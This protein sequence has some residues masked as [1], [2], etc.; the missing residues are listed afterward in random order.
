MFATTLR[1]PATAWATRPAPSTWRGS[2][3]V[4]VRVTT[5]EGLTATASLNPLA[6]GAYSTRHRISSGS[7][8]SPP[9]LDAVG[10]LIQGVA[11]LRHGT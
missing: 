5:R 8:A 4:P 6:R 10:A 2:S 9:P 7:P 1:S 11:R 3:T